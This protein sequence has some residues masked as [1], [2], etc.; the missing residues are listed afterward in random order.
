MKP[1][2]T[3]IA[4]V[5]LLTV[6]SATASADE[7]YACD[8][9][10]LIRVKPGQLE[11]MAKSEPC[12][13]VYVAKPNTA[14]AASQQANRP[15]RGIVGKCR[16]TPPSSGPAIGT[17]CKRGARPQPKP[18][19]QARPLL[20]GAASTDDDALPLGQTIEGADVK[21]KAPRVV[22]P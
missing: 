2:S 13:A 12:L 1:V 22:A 19:A 18:V 9:G 16:T 8:D 6:G 20:R 15:E 21:A 14:V 17:R 5:V 4:A 10:R 3:L 7:Y 11:M